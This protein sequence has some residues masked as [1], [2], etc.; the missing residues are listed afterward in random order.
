MSTDEID[1]LLPD[2]DI[3]DSAGEVVETEDPSLAL[4]MPCWRS[5]VLTVKEVEGG[6]GGFRNSSILSL[7][8][9]DPISFFGKLAKRCN[10]DTGGSWYVA[11]TSEG[12]FVNLPG[13]LRLTLRLRPRESKGTPNSP[14]DVVAV[15]ARSPSGC[16]LGEMLEA[17][18]GLRVDDE[19]YRGGLRETTSREDGDEDERAAR[20][21]IRS[22]LV[23]SATVGRVVCMKQ[24]LEIVVCQNG[25]RTGKTGVK[26]TYRRPYGQL[27]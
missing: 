14:V 12:L 20:E 4:R 9:T 2:L 21:V 25:V 18:S 19:R 8:L 23:G 5:H 11:G 1:V 26:K 6:R 3:I 24:Q 15:G 13:G 10:R 17:R 7:A 16:E 27:P 22:E